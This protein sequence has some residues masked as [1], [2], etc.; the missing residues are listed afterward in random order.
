MHSQDPIV[1]TSSSSTRMVI[2]RPTLQA[3]SAGCEMKLVIPGFGDYLNRTTLDYQDI[4]ETALRSDFSPLNG[5]TMSLLV[6]AAT[7]TFRSACWMQPMM[8]QPFDMGCRSSIS[9]LLENILP[10]LMGSGPLLEPTLLVK[11]LPGVSSRLGNM[12]KLRKLE[13]LRI[14]DELQF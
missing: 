11:R 2:V 7:A 14:P 12:R 3:R 8:L 10:R 5:A 9:I 6:T 4:N 1:A 13:G